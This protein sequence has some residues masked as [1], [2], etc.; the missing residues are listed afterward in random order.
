MTSFGVLPQYQGRGYGSILLAKCNE[1]A[2]EKKL[3]LFLTALPGAYELYLRHG[4]VEVAY[5][6]I[7]LTKW[8]KPHTGYG[9]YR[10]IA[11]VREPKGGKE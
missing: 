3:P 11:M 4:F 2:D 10:N 6:E 8:A 1:I 9:T 7:D 5:G